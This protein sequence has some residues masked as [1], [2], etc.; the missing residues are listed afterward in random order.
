MARGF[1][2]DFSSFMSIILMVIGVLVIVLITNV[3]MI[4]SNPENIRITS[5][6]QSVG[7]YG[8]EGSEVAG[9]HP[10][11]LG[12]KVKEPNYVDVQRDHLVIYPDK[13]I[14]SFRDLEKPGNPF[15][16]LLN[17]LQKKRDEE[18]LILLVRPGTAKVLY[19]LKKIVGDR[20]IDLGF[21]L[22]EADRDVD[23]AYM[24]AAKASGKLK[25]EAK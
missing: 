20:G 16:R 3:V 14:V 7:A 12:N 9:S 1:N 2:Q 15:E 8:D 22:W 25:A 4:V 11:P 17:D 13:E 23:A 18:Y 6:V 10:F 21:E 24:H 19:R 5:L